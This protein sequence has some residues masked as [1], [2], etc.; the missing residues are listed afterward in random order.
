[1]GI[2][3]DKC[4]YPIANYKSIPKANR[5]EYKW[6]QCYYI[7]NLYEILIYSS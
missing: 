6:E 1:M 2:L 5:I 7:Y 4:N 3:R